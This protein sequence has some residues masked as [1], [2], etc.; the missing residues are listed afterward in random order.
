MTHVTC[1]L[2]AKNRDQL[3]NPTLG[4]RVWAAFTFLHGLTCC[5]VFLCVGGDVADDCDGAVWSDGSARHQTQRYP[6]RH[7]CHHGWRRRRVYGPRLPRKLPNRDLC[8]VN[9]LY[10]LQPCLQCF[11][12]VLGA[13]GRRACL[14]GARCRLAYGP[15]DAT[16][17]Q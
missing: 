17:T 1:R 9:F 16:A 8:A 12:A 14:S 13:A 5:D 2:T 11:D 7:P 10:V 4:C 15:A 6:C 3:R